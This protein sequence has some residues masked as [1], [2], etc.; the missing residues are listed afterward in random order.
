MDISHTSWIENVGTGII[1]II[2][3]VS[4]NIL[5]K[6]YIGNF[7]RSVILPHQHYYATNVLHNYYKIIQNKYTL[8]DN[9]MKQTYFSDI[10][11]INDNILYSQRMMRDEE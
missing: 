10:T 4:F 11:K 7:G 5:W 8:V 1:D 2:R 9:S 3:L 6:N